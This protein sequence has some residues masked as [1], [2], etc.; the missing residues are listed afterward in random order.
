MCYM[1]VYDSVCMYCMRATPFPHPLAIYSLPGRLLW[2]QV[3]SSD[4]VPLH[5]CLC[6]CGDKRRVKSRRGEKI[7][8]QRVRSARL[9]QQRQK[10]E[11]LTGFF[12]HVVRSPAVCKDASVRRFC[13]FGERPA[14]RIVGSSGMETCRWRRFP[15][16]PDNNRLVFTDSV[17]R[18]YGWCSIWPQSS[19]IWSLLKKKCVYF[20]LWSSG[21]KGVTGAGRR[22]RGERNGIW[23]HFDPSTCA[24]RSP[25]EAHRNNGFKKAG[26]FEPFYWNNRGSF[27]PNSLYVAFKWRFIIT[28]G[29]LSIPALN[30]RVCL[31]LITVA[32]QGFGWIGRYE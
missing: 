13:C 12:C 24:A 8:Q 15:S 25:A 19:S 4:W 21:C 7:E 17:A 1:C 18:T 5:P 26:D 16:S 30:L 9:S 2:Q 6:V 32:L 20:V 29:L 14:K 3:A 10:K 23:T 11:A 31:P 27:R 22:T 28:A